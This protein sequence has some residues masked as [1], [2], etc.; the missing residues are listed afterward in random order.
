LFRV[1]QEALT[2]IHRHS[3]A[4]DAHIKLARND[5]I[6]FLEVRDAG[7]GMSPELLSAQ[8]QGKQIVGVGILGMRE[9][10]SQLG[11]T[12]EIESSK[13]GT[14]VRASVPVTTETH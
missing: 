2:N 14:T 13:S 12:L 1:V 3:G 4:K 10:L 5:G 8:A 11:G 9:R 6:A 7:K